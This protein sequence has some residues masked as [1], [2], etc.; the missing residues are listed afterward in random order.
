MNHLMQKN[1]ICSKHGSSEEDAISIA[2]YKEYL[3]KYRL[4]DEQ[5]S[6][7]LNCIIG[8][9]DHVINT[10]LDEFEADN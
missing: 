5:I 4:S 1:N 10:Y 7:L 3:A 6:K 9:A 2:E 8:I